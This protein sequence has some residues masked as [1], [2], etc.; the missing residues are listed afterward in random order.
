MKRY[1]NFIFI[2]LS[3]FLLHGFSASAKDSGD[4][5]S[6]L[7]KITAIIQAHKNNGEDL[8]DKAV[9]DSIFDEISQEML[10]VPK[11]K[12]DTKTFQELCDEAKV[13]AAKKY[14]ESTEQVKKK[15]EKDMEKK[16]AM[17]VPM[18]KVTVQY[19]QGN[20]IYTAE[21]TFYSYGGNSVRIESQYIA[22]FDLLPEYRMKFDKSFNELKRKEFFN[23]SLKDYSL[24]KS[25][26][27]NDLI[28]DLREKQVEK[29][30]KAGYIFAYK[31]WRNAKRIAELLL[32]SSREEITKAPPKTTPVAAATATPGT[33][34]E[35]SFPPAKEHPFAP[36][37]STPAKTSPVAKTPVAAKVP[38]TPVQP[39]AAVAPTETVA[40]PAPDSKVTLQ[41]VLE[42]AKKK[43]NE[44][45]NQIANTY[46]GID[47]DQ[48]YKMV[49]WGMTREEVELLIMDRPPVKDGAPAEEEFLKSAGNGGSIL[50]DYSQGPLAQVELHFMKDLLYKVTVR[51]RVL[52]VSAMQKLMTMLNERYGLTDE[53]RKIK[54][55]EDKLKAVDD[56]E[57]MADVPPENLEKKDGNAGKDKGKKKD[58]DK[59][60]DKDK[61]N[62]PLIP[63]EQ[64]FHWTGKIT[65]AT[66]TIRLNQDRSAYTEFTLV[67]ENPNIAEQLKASVKQQELIQKDIQQKKE[68]EEL[69]KKKI[70]F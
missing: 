39:V 57:K 5:E 12:A 59:D 58:K 27:V 63:M 32:E 30:E 67:K 49:L 34:K 4:S 2:T 26:Y 48:G 23:N 33:A 66:V 41:K 45:L 51:F 37:D 43:S 11:E 1:F 31:E 60:K 7:K 44:R 70:D 64:K 24:E 8:N 21:G 68:L 50:L 35:S 36:K 28:K 13:V 16:F 65:Q 52:S 46:A 38:D 22:I 29:N 25:K 61:K 19:K 10:L 17:A 62:V 69:Q 53:V 56:A 55:E 47:A 9:I 20:K 18:E 54:E 15:I 6:R 3:L 42:E 14:P 40:A